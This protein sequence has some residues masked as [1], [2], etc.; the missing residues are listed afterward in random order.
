MD[1]WLFGEKKFFSANLS[2]AKSVRIVLELNSSLCGVI[3]TPNLSYC[4]VST[5]FLG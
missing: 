1:R 4:N 2:P 5:K 3:L